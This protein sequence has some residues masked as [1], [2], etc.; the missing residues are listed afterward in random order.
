[1]SQ[2]LDALQEYKDSVEG[3]EGIAGIVTQITDNKMQGMSGLKLQFW[4]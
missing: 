1:M 2:E 3:H 4:G